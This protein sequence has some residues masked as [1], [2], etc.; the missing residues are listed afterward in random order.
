LQ[1]YAYQGWLEWAKLCE[2]SG[3]ID[4]CK[5]LLKEGLSYCVEN[6][7]LVVKCI[8]VYEKDG[9][10]QQVRKMFTNCDQWRVQVE[11]AQF[12][13]RIGETT[14]AR[15]LFSKLCKKFGNGPVYL[16]ASRY[17]EREGCILESLDYCEEGLDINP[18][19][20]PLWF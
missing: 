20:A 7:N 6:E 15:T 9:D 19:Y 8:K 5:S 11:G 10:F 16:E 13:G 2:E 17:E 1:P 18:R 3:E 4:K 12:E 14:K